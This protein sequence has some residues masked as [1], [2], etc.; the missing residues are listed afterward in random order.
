LGPPHGVVV[1]DRA[2]RKFG[3]CHRFTGI[4]DDSEMVAVQMGVDADDDAP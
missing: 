3:V 4:G 2:R 1:A